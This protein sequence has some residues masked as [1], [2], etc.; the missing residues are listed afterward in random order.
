MDGDEFPVQEGSV[1][2]VSPAGERALCAGD[3]TL[4]YICIQAQAGSLTQ[5]TNEDGVVCESKASW[6]KG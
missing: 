4:V 6:M 5:A 1:V 3:E 2:R